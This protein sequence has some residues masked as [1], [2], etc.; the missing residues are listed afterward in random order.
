MNYLTRADK[1]IFLSGPAGQLEAII[2][3]PDTA[4]Q[5]AV[6]IICHPHPLHGGTMHNKVVHTVAKAYQSLA[7]PALRFNYRGVGESEGSY[8]DAIEETEDLHAVMQWAQQQYPAAKIYLIGFSFG[9]YV[10][11]RAT[12]LYQQHFSI[13]QLI[14]IAPPIERFP[15]HQHIFAKPP[16]VVLQGEADDVVAPEATYAWVADHPYTPQLIRLPGVEH[17]F[18][19]QLDNLKKIIVEQ[20]SL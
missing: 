20:I 10:A 16:I 13:P 5:D 12:A 19:G 18:H 11:L 3:Q 8:G 6:A 9:S 14:L 1:K 17:F 7:I 2:S 15:Y 4:R